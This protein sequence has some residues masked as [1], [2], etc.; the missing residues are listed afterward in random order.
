MRIRSFG[1]PKNQFESSSKINKTGGFNCIYYS[2]KKNQQLIQ[3][4][5]VSYE[6]DRDRLLRRGRPSNFR[7]MMS[8][9][10]R[11]PKSQR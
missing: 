11:K 10:T 2:F 9:G 3:H 8:P 1:Y 6:F 5:P 4:D 7:N